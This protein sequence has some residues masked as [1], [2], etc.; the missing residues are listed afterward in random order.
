MEMEIKRETTKYN[1]F[2]MFWEGF[3][4]M[5]RMS[6]TLWIVAIVKL[7]I[8][9]FILKPFFFPNLLDT[10]Y[11]NEADKAEH[12]RTELFRKALANE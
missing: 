7:I 5:S 3:T 6:K 2:S 4:S 1:W 11:E 9:F 10:N 8:M 12:V